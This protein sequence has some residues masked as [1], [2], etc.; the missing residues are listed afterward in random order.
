MEEAPISGI[1]VHRSL[2]RYMYHGI[3]ALAR[4]PVM[5][6]AC[7]GNSS[8]GIKETPALGCPTVNIGTRQQGRLRGDNVID[9]D[10]DSQEIVVAVNRCLQDDAFRKRCQ[11][12]DNPYSFGDVG[13][14]I[15]SVLAKVR[16]NQVLLRKGMT[17]RAETRNG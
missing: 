6:V 9:T 15:A 11:M 14:R 2:G 3:I 8:S 17:L 5:K 1:Q 10:Y 12:T 4:D 16:I 7:V 13:V